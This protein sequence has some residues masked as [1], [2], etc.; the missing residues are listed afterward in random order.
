MSTKAPVGP[1][2]Q[3]KTS[4]TRIHREI[5]QILAVPDDDDPLARTLLPPSQSPAIGPESGSARRSGI[6][7]HDSPHGS[8]R[9]L[10]YVDGQIASGLQVVSA[11]GRRATIAN[12]YTRPGYRG[13]GFGTELVARA[14][15]D[16]EVVSWPGEGSL[17]NAG[18]GLRDR[19]EGGR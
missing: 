13:R 10:R 18:R 6:G 12:V 4:A 3:K 14:R 5:R 16:F 1:H 2:L 17:S 7:R 19:I 9:Y 11:D 15:R 8:T